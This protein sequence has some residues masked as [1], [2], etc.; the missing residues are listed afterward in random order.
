MSHS[1]RIKEAR[2]RVVNAAKLAHEDGD[3][4]Y[5][6][7]LSDAIE[8]LLALESQTCP[9]CGGTGEE[10]VMV[11]GPIGLMP[12]TTGRACPAACSQGRQDE[13]GRSS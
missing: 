11:D 4:G 2:D 1:D 6:Y 8:E 9:E 3:L 12:F 10:V 5:Q 13:G 7:A